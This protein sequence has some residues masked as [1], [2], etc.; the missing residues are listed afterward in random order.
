M[1]DKHGG[2]GI[3]LT[4]PH[5]WQDIQSETATIECV[6]TTTHE[7]GSF[8]DQIITIRL[9][10]C[11]TCAKQYEAALLDEVLTDS[12]SELGAQIKPVCAECFE[13]FRD[14]RHRGAPLEAPS[15]G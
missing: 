12:T 6:V 7:I 8:V 10:C 13:V 11:D 15:S 3:V 14:S 9:G 4:C 2:Q 5:V 1:C